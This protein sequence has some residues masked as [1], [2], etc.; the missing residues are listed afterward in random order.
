MR[1]HPNTSLR[2]YACSISSRSGICGTNVEPPDTDDSIATV[3]RTLGR[4]NQTDARLKT[5]SPGATSD[6]PR[7]ARIFSR[8]G[9][10]SMQLHDDAYWFSGVR[11][12]VP[13]PLPVAPGQQACWE[14]PEAPQPRDRQ[15][16][17]AKQ[18]LHLLPSVAA[19]KRGSAVGSRDPMGLLPGGGTPRDALPSG[20]ARGKSE[21][22]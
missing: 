8:D 15:K 12:N 1:L 3:S 5:P 11:F 21:F 17:L 19:R 18:V 22:S 6:W 20:Y 13:V 9:E 10:R 14:R 7:A 16:L 4:L 2:G